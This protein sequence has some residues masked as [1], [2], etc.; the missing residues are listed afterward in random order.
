MPR[1]ESQQFRPAGTRV[2]L[3]GTK[4]RSSNCESDV[5]DVFFS[6]LLSTDPAPCISFRERERSACAES[7][8][9]SNENQKVSPAYFKP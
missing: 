4:R 1:S 8:G 3:P 9:S 5:Q 7:F 2:A 6:G